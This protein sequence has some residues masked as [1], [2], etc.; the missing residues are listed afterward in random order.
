MI[1]RVQ[2]RQYGLG[3]LEGNPIKRVNASRSAP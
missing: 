3:L 2:R 1:Q